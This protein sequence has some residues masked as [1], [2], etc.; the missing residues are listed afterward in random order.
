MELDEVMRTTPAVRDYLPDPVPD[1]VLYRI[2]DQARFAPSGGNRQGWR[3]IVVRDPVIRRAI[4]DLYS[5]A[6]DEYI[7]AYLAGD[8]AFAPGWQRPAEPPA[9]YAV[10][11]CERLAEVPVMLLLLAELASLSVTD[12]ELDR[13]SIVGG[14]SVYPFAH[15]V[16][17]AARAEGLGGV[18]T[19]LICPREAEVAELCRIPS[20]YALAAMVCL[21][22]PVRQLTK[23]SRRPV[24]QFAWIDRFEGLP[25]GAAEWE[26][27]EKPPRG[28]R[29]DDEAQ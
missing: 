5:P 23:L 6:E 12:Q 21:G 14:G 28:T 7:R 26:S 29:A 19:T 18:I 10:P 8:V 16:L 20:G 2:L 9:H 1:E 11:F 27:A 4:R 17:L 13:I 22:R 24:E 15:N 25:F 3:V